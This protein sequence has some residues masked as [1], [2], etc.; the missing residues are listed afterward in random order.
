MQKIICVDFDNTITSIDVGN[1]FFHTFSR[2]AD[3]TDDYVN[4]YREGKITLPFL[5]AKEV[6]LTDFNIKKM[7]DFIDNVPYD[8]SFKD[9]IEKYE[10]DY[11]IYILS[12]GFD[13]YIKRILKRMGVENIPFYANNMN[14]EKNRVT[15]NLPYQD[16]ECKQ[17]GNC[18][19]NHLRRFREKYE[20]IIYIGDGI[21]DFCA[22]KEA[23]IVYAK[24]DS[25]LHKK[26]KEKELEGHIF[27]QFKEIIL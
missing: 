11:D 9:F 22:S 16:N 21:S 20:K 26:I 2:N 19:R 15:L 3:A 4:E 8:I 13:W 10:S 7:E 24:K 18:K 27:E 6:F 23:D 12:D 17:C 5:Y 1:R 14:I 25:F